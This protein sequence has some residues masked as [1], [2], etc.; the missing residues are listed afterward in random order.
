[1]ANNDT[2]SVVKTTLSQPITS[3]KLIR[4][5]PESYEQS[6][7]MRVEL[8]G[9]LSDPVLPISPPS[10]TAKPVEPE[11]VKTK[12]NVEGVKGDKDDYA[13]GQYLGITFG[14]IMAVVVVVSCF[15]WWR[16]SR[17]KK[18]KEDT[19]LVLTRFQ[20]GSYREIEREEEDDAV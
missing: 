10:T 15:L 8:Y 4:V 14:L 7:A 18:Q 3:V 11:T 6:I 5:I 13:W 2:K 19:P 12:P 9:C 20:D 1:M 17:N 16:S